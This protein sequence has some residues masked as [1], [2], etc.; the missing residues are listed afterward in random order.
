MIFIDFAHC[1]VL[2]FGA[3]VLTCNFVGHTTL[4]CFRFFVFRYERQAIFLPESLIW[5]LL[6]TNRSLYVVVEASVSQWY[7]SFYSGMLAYGYQANLF[8]QA[9]VGLSTSRSVM[10]K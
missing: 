1:S 6:T 5:F 7:I 9:F 10:D 4:K 2:I 8:L 3:S